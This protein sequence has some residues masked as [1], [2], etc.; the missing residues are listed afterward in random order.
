VINKLQKNYVV[1]MLVLIVMLCVVPK[2]RKKY[3]KWRSGCASRIT[4]PCD[5]D[6]AGRR[7]LVPRGKSVNFT[8]GWL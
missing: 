4:W 3:W 6:F 2:L 5:Q 1:K 8:W 7:N